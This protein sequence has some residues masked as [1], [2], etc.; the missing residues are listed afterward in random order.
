MKNNKKS[1][2]SLS[3]ALIIIAVLILVLVVIQTVFISVYN[4]SFKD[5]NKINSLDLLAVSLGGNKSFGSVIPLFLQISKGSGRVY[6]DSTPLA[7]IDLEYSIKFANRLACKLSNVDCSGLN[8]M[9]SLESGSALL[10]GPSG[11]AAITVLTLATLKGDSIKKGVIMTGT[12][13][14]GGLIGPVGGVDEKIKAAAQN[15]YNLILLANGQEYNASEVPATIKVK[16]VSSIYD[17]Y[18]YFTGKKLNLINKSFNKS[19]EFKSYSKIMS[20]LANKLCERAME[21]F[22]NVNETI[23]DKFREDRIKNDSRWIFYSNDLKSSLNL[24]HIGLNL[25]KNQV[26]YSA[27]SFCFN[28]NVRL[29]TLNYY[30]SNLTKENYSELI[31]K[32]FEL[33][34]EIN[35][36]LNKRK[37][38]SVGD[39]QVKYSVLSR[40]KESINDLLKLNQTI[41]NN[42]ENKNKTNN[43]NDK[44]HSVNGDS[45]NR[46]VNDKVNSINNIS[47]E[48]ISDNDSIK[49]KLVKI[50]ISSYT[51][52]K[53]YYEAYL[54]AYGLERA[55]SAEL[56]SHFFGLDKKSVVISK[57][58]LA[59]SC[60]DLIN[61]INSEAGYISVYVNSS[62]FDYKS[63]LQH[64]LKEAKNHQYEECI[65]DGIMLKAKFNYISTVIFVSKKQLPDTARSAIDSA[66]DQI[67]LAFNKGSWSIQAY[68]YYEYGKA[69]YEEKDYL[70]SLLYSEYSIEFSNFDNYIRR[71]GESLSFFRNPFYNNRLKTV[72]YLNRVS[73]IVVIL[74]LIMIFFVIKKSKDLKQDKK[75]DVRVNSVNSVNSYDEG[76][77]KKSNSND[78]E[79][80][81]EIRNTLG[82]INKNTDKSNSNQIKVVGDH[83]EKSSSNNNSSFRNNREKKNRNEENKKI[84]KVEKSNTR[85]KSIRRSNKIKAKRSVVKN[86]NSKNNNNTHKSKKSRKSNNPKSKKSKGKVMVGKS[87]RSDKIDKDKKGKIK[88]RK[89]SRVSISKSG[90]S[91]SKNDRKVK[92]SKKLP[93]SKVNNRIKK[94]GKSNKSKKGE[95]VKKSKSSSS[96]S[97]KSKI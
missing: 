26:Y 74:L 67:I 84:I 25:M 6:V 22:D 39:I 97:N 62:I 82:V 23:Y 21:Q 2:K 57:Q 37:I 85:S 70:S 43:F 49:A 53:R 96:R 79:T 29:R 36:S 83:T 55:Y 9:Y 34:K 81:K 13:N 14:S 20:S 12:I 44:N 16:E 78:G 42:S 88:D 27:A 77:G 38:T 58:D 11:G 89:T 18:F 87:N 4:E 86:S 65:V 5:K 15:G 80:N 28:A 69:L 72:N 45:D 46:D 92:V 19:N 63:S 47:N 51:K 52:E 1:I 40:L 50:I 30:V 91:K 41:F 75:G 32:G 73:L 56:W 31:N 94:S 3:I 7:N 54:L 17:A 76:N 60:N 33:N 8:F 10:S 90:K 71:S 24:T 59:I 95:K 66:K 64:L 93:K 48:S 61:D 68:T 35:D